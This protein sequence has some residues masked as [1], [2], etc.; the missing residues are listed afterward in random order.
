LN[1]YETSQSGT[2]ID[3]MEIQ[4]NQLNLSENKVNGKN[5]L[6]NQ[7]I[8]NGD[9]SS[10]IVTCE[11]ISVV[12]YQ[13][14]SSSSLS[15][16]ACFNTNTDVMEYLTIVNY[17]NDLKICTSS[18]KSDEHQKTQHSLTDTMMGND[19]DGCWKV[20]DFNGQCFCC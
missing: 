17:A 18:M 13:D 3:I 7:N 8:S 15:F 9:N 10:Q 6:S 4:L 14:T 5:I 2:S 12:V 11:P 20:H 19:I 16:D 1:S